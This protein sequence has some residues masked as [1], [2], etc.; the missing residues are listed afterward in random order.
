MNIVLSLLIVLLHSINI[1]ACNIDELNICRPILLSTT[2]LFQ[3][4]NQSAIFLSTT[5]TTTTSTSFTILAPWI[6]NLLPAQYSFCTKLLAIRMCRRVYTSCLPLNNNNNNNHTNTNKQNG[7]DDWCEVDCTLF[8]ST[9]G[10]LLYYLQTNLPTGLPHQQQ[11]INSWMPPFNCTVATMLSS[12]SSSSSSCSPWPSTLILK[13]SSVPYFPILCSAPLIPAIVPSIGGL[14]GTACD[15]PC[16]SS[17]IPDS[18]WNSGEH[19]IV[20]TLLISFVC[21]CYVATTWVLFK[22]KRRIIVLYLCEQWLI[23]FIQMLNV[24]IHG[25]DNYRLHQCRIPGVIY[26]QADGVKSVRGFFI[27]LESLS[28]M[29]LGLGIFGCWFIICMDL[30]KDVTFNTRESILFEKNYRIRLYLV[31]A[32]VLVGFPILFLIG[33]LSTQSVGGNSLNLVGVT[34]DVAPGWVFWSLFTGPILFIMVMGSF[35]MGQIVYTLWVTSRNAG[36]STNKQYVRPVIFVFQTWLFFGLMI[37]STVLTVVAKSD[38]IAAASTWILCLLLDGTSATCGETPAVSI[39]LIFWYPGQF[40]MVA[41]GLA[42]FFIYGLQADNLLKWKNCIFNI[43]EGKS[44]SSERSRNSSSNTNAVSIAD[45]RSKRLS[46]GV[47]HK[48]TTSTMSTPNK[49]AISL[50]ANV[51][52]S[53]CSVVVAL[54]PKS[55]NYSTNTIPIDTTNLYISSSSSSSSSSLPS[56]SP[57][58]ATVTVALSSSSSSS[59]SSHDIL[60]PQ[61]NSNTTNIYSENSVT[62]KNQI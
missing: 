51:R 17:I 26:T 3:K 9:C 53:S 24:A 39:N 37:L 54:S 46:S 14:A 62:V 36:V 50:D 35:M 13:S 1:L 57:A 10:P 38:I 34:S 47:G 52:M 16:L 5:T 32:S 58:T 31:K 4:M 56:P 12:S 45:K 21:S 15:L 29:G 55:I 41:S 42:N 20:P 2:P 19:M 49:N 60:Y 6:L 22:R 61:S 30:W 7:D 33:A 8:A 11:A 18:A 44:I 27:V 25:V 23:A 48:S 43:L 28:N 40:C 59:S